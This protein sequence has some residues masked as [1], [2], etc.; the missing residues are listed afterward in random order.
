M[1][2]MTKSKDGISKR[3][4]I[5]SIVILGLLVGMGIFASVHAGVVGPWVLSGGDAPLWVPKWVGV[6]LAPSLGAGVFAIILITEINRGH[7]HRDDVHT[8]QTVG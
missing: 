8:A 7:Q 1:V 3:P 2:G 5:L 6:F 4:L